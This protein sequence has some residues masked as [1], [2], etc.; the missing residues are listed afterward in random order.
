M[1]GEDITKWSL[2]QRVKYL[3][4]GYIPEDRQKMGLVLSF[5]LA[6]NLIL[7]LFKYLPFCRHGFL[8]DQAIN[9]NARAAIEKFDIRAENSEI[10]V[11]QLSG[12]NQ[13][14]VVLAR[15]ISGEPMLIIAMQP[16]RGL[17]V[18]ATEYVQQCLSA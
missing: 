4:V 17:D 13:Q 5:S 18:G 8:Q 10:K 14:K 2:P 1:A 11:S 7:K 3:R 12:G 6:K 9:S 16:T 15:E